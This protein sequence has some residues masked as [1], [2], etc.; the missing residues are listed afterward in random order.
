LGLYVY[1]PELVLHSYLALPPFLIVFTWGTRL[2]HNHIAIN[3]SPSCG[4]FVPTP[5]RK[6]AWLAT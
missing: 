3:A 4:E 5:S 2:G 6:F 1:P